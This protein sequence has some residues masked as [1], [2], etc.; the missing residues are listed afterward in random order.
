M[1]NSSAD[2]LYMPAAHQGEDL[3]QIRRDA[4]R[5]RQARVMPFTLDPSRIAPVRPD[6]FDQLIDSML[7][8]QT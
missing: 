6:K 5:Y 3:A 1:E 2:N 4:A 8:P 7:P